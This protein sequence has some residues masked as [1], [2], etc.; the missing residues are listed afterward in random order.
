MSSLEEQLNQAFAF[1]RVS[2]K[3]QQS[4]LTYLNLLKAKDEPTYSHSIRVG[5]LGAKV[6]DYLH[7]GPKALLF[8]GLLHDTGKALIDPKILHKTEEFNREDMEVMKN[9]PEYS[10]QLLKGVH[11]FSA[12]VV[13]RHHQFQED[14]YPV[15]LPPSKFNFSKNTQAKIDLCARILALTDCYD[16]LSTRINDKFGGKRLS[17]KEVKSILLKK[18]PDQESLIEDLYQ[19][20][21]FDQLSIIYTAF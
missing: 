9:H 3:N 19:K 6:A 2:E 5:L 1:Y 12:E 7:L 10:Y 11:E 18:N 21:I 4:A 13:I 8:S 16:A 14:K 17:P 15:K 20:G